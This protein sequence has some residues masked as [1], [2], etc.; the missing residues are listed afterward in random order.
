MKNIIDS[1]NGE[2]A[3]IQ[4][5][6]VK[7][8]TND[9]V[10]IIFEALEKIDPDLK[11]LTVILSSLIKNLEDG[12]VKTLYI[13][14]YLKFYG[15]GNDDILSIRP[16]YVIESNKLVKIPFLKKRHKESINILLDTM[17]I[18]GTLNEKI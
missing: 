17:G 13:I 1:I 10:D 16:K 8:I 7:P 3:K 2:I 18:K 6:K 11:P 5:S 14:S 12:K 4:Y 15:I 9:Q